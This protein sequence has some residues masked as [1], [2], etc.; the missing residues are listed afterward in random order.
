M[1]Q[2][3]QNGVAVTL[4]IGWGARWRHL[5]DTTE[6]SVHNGDAALRIRSADICRDGVHRCRLVGQRVHNVL[7]DKLKF[8]NFAMAYRSSNVL[9]T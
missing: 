1:R 4:C 5:A 7:D 6:R 9:S 2:V 8:E 3:E